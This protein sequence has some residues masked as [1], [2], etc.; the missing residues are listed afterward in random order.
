MTKQEEIMEGIKERIG[1]CLINIGCASSGCPKAEQDALEAQ[2][3]CLQSIIQY[4]HSQG[5]R[6]PNGEALID[7]RN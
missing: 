3:T 7:E 6:L 1:D 4:L 2:E 5:V